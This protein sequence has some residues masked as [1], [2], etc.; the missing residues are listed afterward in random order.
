MSG[1]PF[2]LNILTDL[3]SA[4]DFFENILQASTHY[5]IVGTTVNG[6]IDLWNEGA[7]RLYGY[8]AESMVGKENIS[9]LG[10]PAEM[11]EI[12]LREGTWV[13]KA[14]SK[15]SAG[16]VFIA[17][18]TLTARWNAAGEHVGFLHVSRDVSEQVRRGEA[19]QSAEHKFRSLLEAAPDAMIVTNH[20]G[21]IVLVNA[22]T[23]KLFGYRREELL[24]QE[25]EIL[26]PERHRGRHI[27][28]RAGFL[29]EPRVRPMGAGFELYARRKDGTEFPVEI[30]LGPLE[31]DAGPLVSSAIRDI[32]EHRKSE[33]QI[34]ELNQGLEQRNTE[35]AE[36]NR[37]MEAFIYSVAHDL[38]APLRHMQ[39][40]STMLAEDLGPHIT[41][42]VRES[43]DEIVGSS[44][45]MAEMVDDLL[46]L[47]RVGRQATAL[48]VTSLE[49][50]VEE[51]MRDIRH[52]IG[53]RDIQWEIGELPYIECD[54]G[55][56]RQALSNLLSN[57]VK[58][59]RPRKPAR[60]EVGQ[61]SVGGETAIFV[62]DNGVGFNMKHADKLFGVFQR[63]HR[64]EDFEGTG[65]GLATVQRI[66]HKHGGRVWAEAELNRGATFYF[67]LSARKEELSDP[68]VLTAGGQS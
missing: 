29:S 20:Q 37:E 40:F 54:A 1:S 56:T 27:G 17:S 25:I 61:A 30:S 57:A 12:A 9:I 18:I 15:R 55:L 44:R 11:A 28:H 33:E 13:G 23:E 59:T 60:I 22:Q 52:E 31:T 63:L 2:D 47:A 8:R 21:R 16:A 45:D 32:T 24:D 39:A 10:Q 53:E 66:V 14:E 51:A 49:A 3:R 35:L 4:A 38:R 6:T 67:T 26:V 19:L 50:L 41:P 64:R 48:Q 68:Q 65:V 43:L 34:R 5:S 46:S 36:N 58:Y 62:R 7:S 42:A